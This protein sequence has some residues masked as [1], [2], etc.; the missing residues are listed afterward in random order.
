M[1][2][3]SHIAKS[4]SLA[5]LEDDKVASGEKE[6]EIT[7]LIDSDSEPENSNL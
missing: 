2:T 5:K 1:G 6:E 4:C 3:E 7:N